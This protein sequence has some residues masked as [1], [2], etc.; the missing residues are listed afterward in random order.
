M[1]SGLAFSDSVAG[2]WTPSSDGGFLAQGLEPE[3]AERLDVV[4]VNQLAER[5]VAAR[6]YLVVV[7]DRATVLSP[8]LAEW[9]RDHVPPDRAEVARER[10]RAFAARGTLDAEELATATALLDEPA[11]KEHLA[12]SRSPVAGVEVADELREV[13][14]GRRT[15]EEAAENLRLGTREAA[16][17]LLGKVRRNADDLAL[18][19]ALALLEHQ[20]RSEVE[21]FTALL[22]AR[23]SER[24]PAAQPPAGDDLLGRHIDDRLKAVDAR[25]LPRA[26]E[27]GRSYR[28]WAQPVAFRGRHL[29]DEV[30]RRLWLDYEG[31]SDVLLT[32]LAEL[33][34][35]PGLDRIAGQRI[36]RVLCEASGPYA[37]R[38]LD[39]FAKSGRAW[40]RRLA[41]FALVEVAQDAVLS[42]S[43]RSLLRQWG[44]GAG[45]ELRSTVA[46][47]CAAGL[48]LALPD[49]TLALLAGVLDPGDRPDNG[50]V[51]RAVSAALGVLLTEDANRG[52]VLRSLTDW[53]GE[54]SGTPRRAYAV[55]G[56]LELCGDGFPAVPRAGI[57]RLTFHELY[58]TDWESLVP[59]VLAALDD[60]ALRTPV[61]E[62]LR[63]VETA[64]DA[65]GGD[66]LND[67]LAELGTARGGHRGGLVSFLITRLR[68]GRRTAAGDPYGSGATGESR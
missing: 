59:L 17:A 40:Q 65:G 1:F 33:P 55:Q 24:L 11:F 10:L 68:E 7:V 22:R 5:L 20:D 28:Y 36:G 14:A 50:D 47:T 63:A 37:L 38:Q 53:L 62:A 66:R 35:A 48:G 21:R 57:R 3:V 51:R 31:F 16:V 23:I 19:A 12:E 6:A 30:L 32:W 18:A 56:V 45:P 43:V 4:A 49:F 13:A 41:G 58:A 46:E 34:Y 42:S 29:A 9:C 15:V 54:P 52:P 25:L 61:A 26:P 8:A 2:R 60:T 67:F 27:S 44:R 39:V 64:P